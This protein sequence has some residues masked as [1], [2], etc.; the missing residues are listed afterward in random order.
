MSWKI[1]LKPL[2]YAVFSVTFYGTADRLN[3]AFGGFHDILSLLF[4][5]FGQ[6]FQSSNGL[7]RKGENQWQF[8]AVYR[9]SHISFDLAV[10]LLIFKIAV[11]FPLFQKRKKGKQDE[12]SIRLGS[13]IHFFGIGKKSCGIAPFI[14]CVSKVGKRN[15][16][17]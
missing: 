13:K 2:C 14:S 10:R 3:L 15:M 16:R 5:R 4:R 12:G 6:R 9:I 7:N 8:W 1:K 17:R 11:I